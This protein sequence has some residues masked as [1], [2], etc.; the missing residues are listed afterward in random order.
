M[1]AMA[2]GVDGAAALS[3]KKWF[4]TNYHYL[5]PEL[6]DTGKLDKA[7]FTAYLASVQLGLDKL[8]AGNAVPV[9][10]GPV[11]LVSLT[12]FGDSTIQDMSRWNLLSELLPRYTDLLAKIEALGARQV[13]MQEPVL[14]LDDD[15]LL[16]LF[17]KAYPNILPDGLDIDI[18]SYFEDIGDAN[19]QWLVSLEAISK[20]SLDFTRGNNLSLIEK[21]GFPASKILGAGLIDSRSVWKLDTNK[22]EPIVGKLKGVVEKLSIQPSAS[23]QYVPWSL[24]SEPAL[25]EHDAGRVLAFGKEKLAEVKAFSDRIRAGNTGVLTKARSDWEAFS[26]SNLRNQ[27]VWDRLDKLSTADLARSEP[28]VD[29]RKKQLTGLPALPTTTIG[30]FPQTKEIRSLRYKLKKGLLSQAEY[31]KAIDQQIA[32]MIGI[33]EGLGLDILVHG[34]PERTDMV[35]FFAHQMD[36]MLFTSNGWV[37][38]FGSRCVRPPIFWA[39]IARSKNDKTSM[40]VREYTVAQSFTSKPVKG[41]LTGPLTILNWSFPRTDVSEQ[42]QAMQIALALRD[43]IADLEEAGCRVIQV[44]EPALREGMPMRSARKDEYLAWAAD[45]FRLST[46][47]AASETQIHT[48]M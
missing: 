14:V 16:P 48:H 2:R 33:Q 21:H 39:D 31:E 25:L 13:Q 30:S 3:L 15:K 20:I 4:D 44:D 19:Y 38:S 41:M 10:L 26:K 7:N 29:R 17:Q 5:V 35:E 40:T 47:G 6:G 27:N 45:A 46:S 24:E 8:G 12:N 23:L 32:L 36:G 37:Q 22:I 1:F 42:Q 18:V 11:T 28:F 34:E 9:V 43:E